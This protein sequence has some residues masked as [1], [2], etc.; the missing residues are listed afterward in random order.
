V[1][2]VVS[3]RGLVVSTDLAWDGTVRYSVPTDPD[4]SAFSR[5]VVRNQQRYNAAGF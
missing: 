3:P 4:F 5:R 1:G 2:N